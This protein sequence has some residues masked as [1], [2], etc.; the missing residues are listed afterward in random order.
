MN[1]KAY[2]ANPKQVTKQPFPRTTSHLRR[3]GLASSWLV[4]SR[5]MNLEQCTEGLRMSTLVAAGRSGARGSPLLLADSE[6]C[7]EKI[8]AS[9]DK[10]PVTQ[11]APPA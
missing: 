6:H 8:P 10:P 1:Q 3:T 2:P 7:L 9:A 5:G 4:L 11:P